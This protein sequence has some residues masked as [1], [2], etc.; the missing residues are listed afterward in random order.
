MTYDNLVIATGS[1]VDFDVAPGV[2]E[3]CRY[4]GTPAR[5]PA[6]REALQELKKRS[7][8]VMRRGDTICWMYGC[9]I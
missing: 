2:R 6:H 1:K 4:I 9:R 8:Q 3:Y 5:R 7:S